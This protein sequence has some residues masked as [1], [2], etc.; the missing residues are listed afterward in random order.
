MCL[1]TL[2]ERGILLSMLVLDRQKD[3]ALDALKTGI[4][5]RPDVCDNVRAPSP[6]IAL[7]KERLRRLN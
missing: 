5:L 2:S 7:A 4:F 3:A 1:K 6:E